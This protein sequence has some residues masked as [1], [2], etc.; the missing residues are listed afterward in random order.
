PLLEEVS[1][2]YSYFTILVG[3]GKYGMSR[4]QLFE[5][6]KENGVNARKYFYPLISSFDS[7]K[8]LPSANKEN[9][10]VACFTS[11]HVLCLPQFQD[12]KKEEVDKIINI[13]SSFSD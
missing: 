10:P 8:N 6:L 9:L 5:K 4:D 11:R 12:L 3:P 13:I 7:Y 2:P 1:V